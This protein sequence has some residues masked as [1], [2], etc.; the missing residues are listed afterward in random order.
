MTPKDMPSVPRMYGEHKL[1][2]YKDAK[3]V[4]QPLHH[5]SKE[6]RTTIGFIMEVFHPEWLA[7]C[8]D[9]TSNDQISVHKCHPWISNADTHSTSKDL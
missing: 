1:H 9:R 3:P 4:S 2:V 5:F 8:S 6:K 7:N